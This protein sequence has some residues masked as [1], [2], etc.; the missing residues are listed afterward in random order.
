M[1]RPATFNR[2]T[3]TETG[4]MEFNVQ[5]CIYIIHRSSD[6]SLPTF[7]HDIYFLLPGCKAI[8]DFRAEAAEIGDERFIIPMD[9]S[10]VKLLVSICPI[11]LSNCDMS[12]KSWP[13]ILQVLSPR[14]FTLPPLTA[15]GPSIG[16]LPL[17]KINCKIWIR[18]ML[19][20]FYILKGYR[21]PILDWGSQFALSSL[22]KSISKPWTWWL[23]SKEGR[24]WR[25]GTMIIYKYWCQ[26]FPCMQ[27][28]PS[29]KSVTLSWSKH[30]GIGPSPGLG[31][32]LVAW[33]SMSI[34]IITCICISIVKLHI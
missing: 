11:V 1:R 20:P 2:F 10:N 5:M 7:S 34:H 24:I 8:K 33:A 27:V 6:R 9:L 26:H 30:G 3:S 19:T 13:C 25:W 14:S 16:V 28:N 21:L 23:R 4:G 15:K 17:A 31:L 18:V 29:R 22:A 32:E 12:I